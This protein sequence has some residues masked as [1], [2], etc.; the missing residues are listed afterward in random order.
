MMKMD[1]TPM[2]SIEKRSCPKRKGRRIVQAR[3]SRV[4]STVEPSAS[5]MSTT[6]DRIPRREIG[7]LSAASFTLRVLT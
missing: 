4:S 5:S 7:S 3:V 2:N 1:S 6:P